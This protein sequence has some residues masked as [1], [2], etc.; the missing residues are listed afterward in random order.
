[1]RPASINIHNTTVRPTYK[2][3]LNYIF[4]TQCPKLFNVLLRIIASAIQP[5]LNTVKIEFLVFIF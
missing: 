1:M 2:N 3:G 4:V 5:M